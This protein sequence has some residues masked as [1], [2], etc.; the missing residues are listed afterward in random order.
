MPGHAGP[1]LEIDQVK[2]LAQFDVIQRL[3]IEHRQRRL[4]AEE[5][6]I[7]LIVRAQRG[8]GMR[9]VG[10][11]ALNR[12]LL[13]SDAIELL[14]DLAGPLAEAAALFLAARRARPRPWPCRSTSRVRSPGD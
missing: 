9:E 2:P 10:N 5:F 3:E 6:Q 11:R 14:L 4:A 13:G 7:G 12:L 1:A 8:V